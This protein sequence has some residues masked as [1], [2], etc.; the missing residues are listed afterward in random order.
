MNNI[1]R[2]N[3]YVIGFPEEKESVKVINKTYQNLVKDSNLQIQEVQ[4]T[5]S[6]INT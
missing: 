4:Q 5:L 3:I 2:S 6:R 1:K